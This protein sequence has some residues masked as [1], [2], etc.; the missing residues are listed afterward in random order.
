MTKCI[1]VMG[2][3][4]SGKTTLAQQIVDILEVTGKTVSWLN[5]DNIRKEYNDWDF[6][7]EGRLRQSKRMRSLADLSNTD[8]VI[9]DFVA[10]LQEMRN[11]FNADITVWVNTITA[12]RFTDTN[13]LFEVPT[14][15]NFEVISQ[16]ARYWAKVIVDTLKLD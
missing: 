4:G 12:G 11:I 1:L 2:L 9:C 10:P 7:L 3:P 5:A 6:S 13:K 16:D 14:T 8:Y 15:V